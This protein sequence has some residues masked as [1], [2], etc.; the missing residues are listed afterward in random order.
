[1]LCLAEHGTVWA[2]CWRGAPRAETSGN[3]SEL[4]QLGAGTGPSAML[5]RSAQP[6]PHPPSPGAWAA[7]GLSPSRGMLCGAPGCGLITADRC[8]CLFQRNIISRSWGRGRTVAHSTLHPSFAPCL[9]P[10]WAAGPAKG[11]A[12]SSLPLFFC[13]GNQGLPLPHRGHIQGCA[14]APG[15]QMAPQPQLAKQ[16]PCL[17]QIWIRRGLLVSEHW[18]PILWSPQKRGCGWLKVTR[19]IQ[20]AWLGVNSPSV[21][22]EVFGGCTGPQLHGASPQPW[23]GHHL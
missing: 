23:V 7:L 20:E 2:A 11:G 1:M 12:P 18:G 22:T 21:L 8:T 19:V 3:R 13:L 17:W 15:E 6:T 5:L 9:L 14:D 4:G 10:A 16:L